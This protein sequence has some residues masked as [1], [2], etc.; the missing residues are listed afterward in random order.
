MTATDAAAWLGVSRKTLYAYVSRGL[1]QAMRDPASLRSNHYNMLDLRRLVDRKMQRADLSQLPA[2]ALSFGLPVLASK[3]TLIEDGRLFYRGHD[4][5]TLATTMT[6]EDVASLLWTGT[7]GKSAPMVG[8]RATQPAG[9]TRAL[10]P[11]Q[12]MVIILAN[13]K[14]LEIEKRD[15]SVGVNDRILRLLC[16]SLTPRQRRGDRLAVALQRHFAPNHPKASRLFDALLILCADHELNA[17]TFTVR[18]AASTLLLPSV[19]VAAGLCTLQGERHGGMTQRWEAA[20]RGLQKP[21]DIAHVLRTVQTG[22]VG[23]VDTATSLPGFGHVLYPAGDPRATL[24]LNMMAHT[25]DYQKRWKMVRDLIDA[26]RQIS[27]Q[28]PTIDIALAALAHVLKAEKGA[29]LGWFALGRAAGWLA[30][31]REQAD[32]GTMIRPRARY[33]GLR[34]RKADP[35]LLGQDIRADW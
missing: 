33:V 26:G 16:S 21:T 23:V 2:S 7:P 13:A 9:L 3:I 32:T 18:C 25:F 6:F 11:I 22:A 28:A 8:A 24:L 5:V 31:A 29:A 4:A 14:F 34:P 30:H 15:T 19:A 27:G 1:V 20:L 17:S 10:T 35:F 12:R